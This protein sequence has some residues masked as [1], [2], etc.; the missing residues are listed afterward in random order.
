VVP[1]EFALG[2][3]LILLKEN[4]RARAPKPNIST[5]NSQTP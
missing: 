1:S 4:R 2:T 3:T 5:L